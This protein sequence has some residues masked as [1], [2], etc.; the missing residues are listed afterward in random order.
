MNPIQISEIQIIQVKPNN[1]LIA[2]ASFILNESL[3]VSSIAVYTRLDNPDRYR[4]VYPSKL[5]GNKETN[6][7]YPIKK[8]VGGYIEKEVSK[9]YNKLFKKC[10]EYVR[11]SNFNS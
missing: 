10:D 2:F 11:Y 6:I 7:L 3:F 1:G 4:L 9:Q 8:E 5:I